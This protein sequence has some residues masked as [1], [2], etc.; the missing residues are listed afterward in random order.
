MNFVTHTFTQLT[1]AQL[2]ELLKARQAVF[3]VEQNCAYLDSDGQD[4]SAHHVLGLHHQQL[5]CYARILPPSLHTQNFPSIGRV[6]TLP[7]FRGQQLAKQLMTFAIA[8][9]QQLYG[10]QP[11]YI[12]AQVYLLD[13]YQSLGFGLQGEIYLEDNIPHINMVLPLIDF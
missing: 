7:K 13:F 12:S 11:I 9:C 1:T 10:Q 8:E 2:Y 3:V 6:L 5:A 4:F